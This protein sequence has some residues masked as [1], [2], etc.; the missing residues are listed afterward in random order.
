[1]SLPS[2]V[3]WTTHHVSCL[4]KDQSKRPHNELEEQGKSGGGATLLVQL[5]MQ[6]QYTC[7]CL[8]HAIS[9]KQKVDARQDEVSEGQEAEG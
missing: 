5:D 9:K 6:V 4:T 1:M 2:C 8:H 3:D 7:Q